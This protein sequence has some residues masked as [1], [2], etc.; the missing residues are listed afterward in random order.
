MKV[1]FENVVMQETTRD[2]RVSGISLWI[3]DSSLYVT[4]CRTPAN[5]ISVDNNVARVSLLRAN[6]IKDL[7]NLFCGYI[8]KVFLSVTIIVFLC[9]H[10]RWFLKKASRMHRYRCHRPSPKVS[11]VKNKMHKSEP[12][13]DPC[14]E[15]SS[16]NS[17][18]S[19][20]FWSRVLYN[21]L[22]SIRL[23]F[24]AETSDRCRPEENSPKI[25]N[26]STSGELSGVL[27]YYFWKKR[28]KRNLIR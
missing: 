25:I 24:A 13:Y 10:T 7:Y 12:A 26:Q 14:T 17:T 1:V 9:T 4:V 19:V 27:S 8:S 11:I 16:T 2:S 23:G 22:I 6:L 3:S 5:I 21:Y 15:S 20:P 28:K 18:Y